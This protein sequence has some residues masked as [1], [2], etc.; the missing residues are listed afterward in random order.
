[1]SFITDIINDTLKVRDERGVLR[2]SKTC[3]TMF[4]ACLLVFW[5]FIHVTLKDG[6]NEVAFGIMA[7]MALGAGVTKSWGKKI[8]QPAVQS[9]SNDT[10]I[11]VDA[12]K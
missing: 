8:E 11:N 1:M 4:G 3:L 12:S 9:T 10:N 7:T 6:F 5:S 2:Y